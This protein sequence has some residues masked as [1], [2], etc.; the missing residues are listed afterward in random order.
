MSQFL[1][2]SQLESLLNSLKEFVTPKT[3]YKTFRHLFKLCIILAAFYGYVRGVQKSIDIVRHRQ[4]IRLRDRTLEPV[5]NILIQIG[6][7]TVQP[8]FTA[9]LT[10]AIVATAPVSIPYILLLCRDNE[11]EEERRRRDDAEDMRAMT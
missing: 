10:A 11:T 3:L 2:L 7:V 9:L 6:I 1:A 8:L 4:P 5:V